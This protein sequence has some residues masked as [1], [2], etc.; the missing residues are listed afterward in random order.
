MLI[1]RL[2][3]VGK[4]NY[5]QFKIVVAEKSAP[6][7]GRFVEQLGSYD[8]HKKIVTVDSARAKHWISQGAAC[9]DTAWNLLISQGVIEGEKRKVK[10]PDKVAEQSE[11]GEGKETAEKAS[12]DPKNSKVEKKGE[13]ASEEKQ[14]P[15]PVAEETQPEKELESKDDSEEKKEKVEGEEQKTEEKQQV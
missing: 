11:E 6:V 3:R 14:A 12:E 15:E 5:P 7:K 8:P 4:R 1:I 2:S 10:I 9:S 13:S